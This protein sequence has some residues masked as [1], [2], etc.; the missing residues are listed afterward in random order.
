MS[1]PTVVLAAMQSI[2]ALHYDGDEIAGGEPADVPNDES[3][4]NLIDAVES[5][6]TAL[7]PSRAA[8]DLD[9]QTAR[10]MLSSG[11]DEVHM[12]EGR[13]LAAGFHFDGP[14]SETDVV[15][16]RCGDRLYVWVRGHGHPLALIEPRYGSEEGQLPEHKGSVHLTLF[17][18]EGEDPLLEMYVRGGATQVYAERAP[19]R[20]PGQGEG[21]R[22]RFRRVRAAWSA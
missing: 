11:W 9:G 1:E 20:M 5:A 22:W 16:E 19:A 13:L 4:E 8:P 18:P 3:H 17:E 12:A 14:G 6:R 21:S 15:V 7:H 2:A 10:A